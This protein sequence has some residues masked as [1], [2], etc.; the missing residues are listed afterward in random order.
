MKLDEIPH[1]S[2]S[3]PASLKAS[4]LRA[5]DA[6]KAFEQPRKFVGGDSDAA[7]LD[8]DAGRATVA[9]RPHGH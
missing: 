5:F 4:A 8:L 1:K 3:D 2:K 7:V 6:M 9:T